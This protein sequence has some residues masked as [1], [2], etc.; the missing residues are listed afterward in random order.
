M[1]QYAQLPG[2][3]ARTPGRV[4]QK[5][6]IDRSFRG[7]Y[8]DYS[9]VAD[10]RRLYRPLFPNVNANTSSDGEQSGVEVFP[11]Y[12]KTSPGAGFVVAK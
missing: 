2:E 7:K 11:W 9:S 12:L 4:D 10:E 8:A 6:G 3:P 5:A 1:H